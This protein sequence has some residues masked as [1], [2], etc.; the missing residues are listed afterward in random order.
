MDE[1]FREGNVKG[2]G[3][4]HGEGRK[5]Y[6]LFQSHSCDRHANQL[7]GNKRR[8]HTAQAIDQDISFQQLICRS[9]FHTL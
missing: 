3:A 5:R 8:N 2:V 1:E 7:N 4:G 6:V 9:K